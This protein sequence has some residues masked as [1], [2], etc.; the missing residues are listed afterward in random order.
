M[1]PG[2]Q[3]RL[4]SPQGTGTAAV[5]PLQPGSSLEVDQLF[6]RGLC[7]WPKDASLGSLSQWEGFRGLGCSAA[8]PLGWSHSWVCRGG[9]GRR[10]GQP[11]EQR[12]AVQK[13][14]GDER[15]LERLGGPGGGQALPAGPSAP[16]TI[17]AQGPEVQAAPSSWALTSGH[18]AQ[19][20]TWWCPACDCG[21]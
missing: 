15:W 7:A 10:V 2:S 20:G 9:W 13:T 18:G 6:P 8:W 5:R 21:P 16:D 12:R 19:A 1:W 3:P 4:P 14:E 11:L 17:P